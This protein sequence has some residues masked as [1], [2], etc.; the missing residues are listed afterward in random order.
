MRKIITIFFVSLFL[1]ATAFA[2][3]PPSPPPGTIIEL[4]GMGDLHSGFDRSSTQ[5]LVQAYYD[6]FSQ[7]I[8]VVFNYAS[9]VRV[10]ILDSF[11][12]TVFNQCYD[13]SVSR[14]VNFAAPA[15]SGLYYIE[16]LSPSF[17]VGGAFLVE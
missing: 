5:D 10:V 13:T 16:I 12:A 15:T 7:Q 2:Q 3:L 14:I 9:D 11:S 17:A 1:C 6:S 8:S 4:E